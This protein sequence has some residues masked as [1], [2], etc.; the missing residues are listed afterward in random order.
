MR[1]LLPTIDS[2][3]SG[4]Q[5][6]GELA[7]TT[8]SLF[9]DQLTLDMSRVRSFDAHMAAPLG[10]VLAH[11]TDRINFV[12]IVSVPTSIEPGSLAE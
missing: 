12:E 7:E 4:F 9:A 1:Y 5:R 11:V 6:L 3:V 8:E 2:E 10:T